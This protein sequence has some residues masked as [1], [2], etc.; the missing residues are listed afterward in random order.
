MVIWR[1]IYLIL[2]ELLDFASTGDG[3]A[4]VPVDETCSLLWN[5][6]YELLVVKVY[7]SQLIF[8]Y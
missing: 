1:G 4:E 6:V 8:F 3:E 5:L 2:G 7:D